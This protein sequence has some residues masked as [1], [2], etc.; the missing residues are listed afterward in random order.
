[1]PN[2]TFTNLDMTNSDALKNG[3]KH[4]DTILIANALSPLQPNEVKNMFAIFKKSEIT[5]II[6]YSA[7]DLRFLNFFII[8]FKRFFIYRGAMWIGYLYNSRFISGLIKAIGFRRVAFYYPKQ[9][10]VLTPVFGSVYLSMFVR[11]E[12]QHK[13]EMVNREKLNM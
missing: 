2:I 1:M 3:I 4:I 6:I 13:V 10:G 8:L 7:E 9:H 12:W 5:K 11:G